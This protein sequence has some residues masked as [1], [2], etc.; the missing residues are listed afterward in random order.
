MD[1]DLD[2]NAGMKVI[3][4]RS[5]DIYLGNVTDGLYKTIRALE[6]S[7]IIILADDNTVRHCVPLVEAMIDLD[8]RIIIAS[9]DQHKTLE[10]CETIWSSL[11]KSGADRA[12]VI[13]NVGGGMICDLGGFAAACYQRGIRF[14]H[15]PTSLLPWLMLRWEAKQV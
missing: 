1:I 12:S 15:I 9:G 6:P 5:G 4:S 14:A 13:L 2:R 3:T 10:S 7:M 11:A 8:L